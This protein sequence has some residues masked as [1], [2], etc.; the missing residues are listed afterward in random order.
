MN[1]DERVVQ[2]LREAL[3]E[4]AA[5]LEPSDRLDEI[6][7]RAHAVPAAT[8]TGWRMPLAVA[9]AAAAVV[10]VATGVWLGRPDGSAPVPGGS[11]S[12][13]P[14]A[15]QSASPTASP[16]PQPT[17]TEQPS[18]TG[19]GSTPP[20]EPAGAPVA[21]PVYYVAAIGDDARMVRLY[22]E[23]LTV[24]GVTR[25]ADDRLRARTA[26]ELAMTA[27]P[28]GTDGY[29]RTW[30]GVDLLDVSVTDARIT[31]TLSG[32]GRTAFPEDT[33][34]VSVQQLVW[35]VQAAVGRGTIPVRFVLA[36]GSEAMFGTHPVDRTYNRP[37]SRDRYHE[38]L[39]PIWVTSP[40]RG[41]VLPAGEVIVTGE[42]SVFEATVSWELLREGDVVDEGFVTA[43]DGAPG[44]GTY[45][46]RLD[47][48]PRGAYAIR[49]FELSAEDGQTVNAETTMPFT[50]R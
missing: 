26:V 5:R 42:A 39:A 16:S 25:S 28:P 31:I 2:A 15:S 18:P 10:A 45:E 46:I 20:P 3:D 41:Q 7:E 21:L 37:A 34:R 33:E 48:L 43:T 44:R 4:R 17:A 12:P 38:D 50:L 29:L 23:W 9:A 35:T 1:D 49:V 19:S 47:A 32:P 11:D 14:S 30:D 8:W 36:D 24:P 6:L 22:R 27:V 40:T 13:L